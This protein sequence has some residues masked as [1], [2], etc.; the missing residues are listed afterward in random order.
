MEIEDDD[1]NEIVGGD[2]PQLDLELEIGLSGTVEPSTAAGGS[3]EE[4]EHG[5]AEGW[6]RAN[7]EGCTTKQIFWSMKLRPRASD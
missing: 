7:V 5:D 4:E 6:H 3:N 1:A 2:E